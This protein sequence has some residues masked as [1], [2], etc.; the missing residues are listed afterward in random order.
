M[1]DEMQ[2]RISAQTFSRT[3]EKMCNF[4]AV[5]KTGD[6]KATVRGI[7]TLCLY[8]LPD[9]KF[10]DAESFKRTIEIMFGLIIPLQQLQEA[11]DNLERQ[12]I[13]LRPGNS[14]YRLAP[15]TVTTLEH[16]IRD[17]QLLEERVKTQWL[18]ELQTDFP[19]LPPDQIWK[20][21]QTYLC[22]TFRRHGIQA[23]ALID[24]S[25]DS[26]PEHDESLSSI[27]RESV[28]GIAELPKD[29][30]EGAIL[31][32]NNFMASLGGNADRSRY[33]AQSADGAFNFYTLE[34]PAD[35]S[36]QFRKQLH[37]LTL[38]LDTNFLFGI[39]DL[40][41]NTQVQ[42]SHDLIKAVSKHNLPFKL[43]FHEATGREMINTIGYYGSILR[44][45]VWNRTLSRAATA[46]RNLSGIE[47][48]FHEMNCHQQLDVDEFIRTYE[49]F[50]H[51][52]LEKNIKIYRP[53]DERLEARNDIYHDYRDFLELNGRGDKAYETVMHDATILAEVQALRSQAPSSL[54]A[55]ALLV[56]CDYYLFRYNWE[57][58]R[59]TG[60]RACVLMPNML[61]QILRPFLPIDQDNDKAFAETF[62]LPQFRILGSGGSKACSKM[63]QILATYKEVPEETAMKMMANDLLLDQLKTATS[64]AQFE[65]Q[66]EVAFVE[67]NRNLIEERVY[68]E[69]LIKNEKA[70]LQAEKQKRFEEQAI[71]ER[72]KQEL[73]SSI[74]TAE[75]Y[76]EIAKRS[77]EEKDLLALEATERAQKAEG[78]AE[79]AHGKAEREVI[80]NE[81]A[82]KLALKMTK[83]TGL[84]FGICLIL[85]FM[86]IAHVLPWNWMIK[87][88][89]SISIQ[90]SI[91]GILLLFPLGLPPPW[92]S[93]GHPFGDNPLRGANE[94]EG[95]NPAGRGSGR[96]P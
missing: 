58:A 21:L 9:E 1:A 84:A 44:S 34:V 35:L 16:A 33:I 83:L 18:E 3:F 45:R 10:D 62:A 36:E 61:W 23:A 14:N 53:I 57:I 12:G 78:E 59:K 77:A 25:I 20:A 96:R 26:Q 68:L 42:I 88:N 51:L 94:E 19:K 17:A 79:R 60:H 85:L 73:A 39:L 56:T 11:A 15:A 29:L 82:Q 87:H 22:K 31:A 5:A 37:A 13:L 47:Q 43:R 55:G 93:L 71:H 41:Y 54:D 4:I 48:K 32:V 67:E 2:D 89:N 46:N 27:L 70:A 90:I 8:E 30:H 6:P 28:G 80:E 49:H 76:I 7:L 24:P 95:R 91:S 75:K 50:D 92:Y 66:V 74:T 63:L 38:F 72:E 65:E 64:D 81:S 69:Q 40:H 52:L 86:L